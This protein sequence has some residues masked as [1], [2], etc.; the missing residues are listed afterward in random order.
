MVGL[1]AI[2]PAFIFRFTGN[3]DGVTTLVRL[4][5]EE[6]APYYPGPINWN[7]NWLLNGYGPVVA[8]ITLVGMLIS[9]AALVVYA[10]SVQRAKPS[11]EFVQAFDNKMS[12]LE[13]KVDEV[14][15]NAETNAKRGSSVVEKP[16]GTIIDRKPH[17]ATIID[18][19]QSGATL[20][21]QANGGHGVNYNLPASDVTIGR[22]T[23]CFIVVSDG[24]VSDVHAKLIYNGGTWLLLDNGSTNGTYL[25]GQLVSGQQPVQNGDTIKAGDTIMVFG[26]AQ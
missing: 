12:N 25:N 17:A 9:A 3:A 24:K 22:G 14:R 2:L 15:R 6:G 19:P 26:N 21:V 8:M 23:S 7:V 5:A 20:T 1:F 10:S 13:S 18:L 16:A 4:G 11:T